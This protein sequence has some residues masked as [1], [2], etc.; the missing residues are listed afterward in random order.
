MIPYYQD[1]FMFN[2]TVLLISIAIFVLFNIIVGL[3]P[4]F[5]VIRKTPARILSRNDVDWNKKLFLLIEIVFYCMLTNNL[6]RYYNLNT[7]VKNVEIVKI[8]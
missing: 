6:K 4:V 1:Q 3:L 2:S 7:S 8:L 5:N